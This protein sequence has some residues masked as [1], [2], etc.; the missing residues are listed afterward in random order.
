MQQHL[1]QTQVMS[2]EVTTGTSSVPVGARD[3]EAHV[4]HHPASHLTLGQLSW[5]VCG[6]EGAAVHEGEFSDKTLFKLLI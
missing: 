4:V 3:H 5:G 1:A 2:H 6:T